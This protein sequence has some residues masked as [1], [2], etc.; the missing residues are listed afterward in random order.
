[1]KGFC[2][3]QNRATGLKNF[4]LVVGYEVSALQAE[5]TGC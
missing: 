3:L 5:S 2:A 4:H 1:M